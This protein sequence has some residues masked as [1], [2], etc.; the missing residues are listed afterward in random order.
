MRILTYSNPFELKRVPELWDLISSHPHYCAS[1]TLVQG[2]IKCYG[3]EAFK[4]LRPINDLLEAFY[5][6]YSANPVNDM[7]LFLTVAN[8]IRQWADGEV[9]QA[10]LFNKAEVVKAIQLLLPLE[11]DVNE[12]DREGLPEEQRRLLDLMR[13]VVDSPCYECFESCRRKTIS[14][15]RMAVEETNL[16]EINYYLGIL[17]NSENTAHELDKLY[18]ALH[19]PIKNIDEAERDT[20]RVLEYFH[21]R[22]SEDF[23][24]PIKTTAEE[25]LRL[26]KEILHEQ[27]NDY[28]DTV[29]FHGI[30]QIS[31]LMFFLFR[32]LE[33][34]GI[35]VVFLINYASNLPKI[36]QTWKEVYSWCDTRFEYSSPVDLDKGNPLGRS[37]ANVIEGKPAGDVHAN[38]IEYATMSSFATNEAGR[39]Y[40]DTIDADSGLGRLDQMATQYY[41]VQGQHCNEILRMYYPEQFREKPFLAYPIGQFIIGLYQ[42]WDFEEK[43]LRIN[44]A[45]LSECV[46][47]GVFQ[48]GDRMLE[49]IRRTR[50]LFSDV[51]SIEEYT[52]RFCGLE[53]ARNSFSSG[54]M[55]DWEILRQVSFFDLSDAD[56]RAFR[57]YLEKI[58]SLACRLFSGMSEHVDYLQHF[59]NLIEL[60]SDPKNNGGY[61]SDSERVLIEEITSRLSAPGAETVIGNTRDLQEALA[62]FLSGRM[63]AD[64]SNWI[65]RDFMQIDGAV[66]MSDKS[67][68][69][70]YHFALLSNEHM[71]KNNNHDLP[72]PLTNEM[73]GQ[74]KKYA[75]AITAVTAGHREKRH[76]L[77]YILFYGIFFSRNKNIE[78]SYIKEEDGETQSPYYLL[79]A[80]GMGKEPFDE[81]FSLGF[82]QPDSSGNLKIELDSLGDDEK[83]LFTICPFKY[84]FTKVVRTPIEYSSEY[85]IKYYLSFALAY[86]AWKRIHGKKNLASEELDRGIRE[87]KVLFPFWGESVFSDIKKQASSDLNYAL[88]NGRPFPYGYVRRKRNFL[89][90]KWVDPE[91]GKDCFVQSP[92]V[93][94]KWAEYMRSSQI[95]PSPSDLPPEGIC[96][97]CSFSEFCLRGFYD[98]HSDS[99]EG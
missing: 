94:G 55:A 96:N 44:P 5:K 3:R 13:E 47:S 49:T 92:D 39:Q 86:V 32:H 66:L 21:K 50:L 28:Y 84:L 42:M 7:Q 8:A 10:F 64:T 26:T 67:K 38:L 82:V 51:D 18:P 57:A 36:F 80:I 89:V 72:W 27:G 54:R 48:P 61:I 68:A 76:F 12:F 63:N 85:H 90:A 73:F 33:K 14:D 19:L 88:S 1:D 30:H 25:N 93:D 15:Y 23:F 22:R 60:I 58:H 29:V 40:A 53:K 46:V 95:Y 69:D 43:R 62:F 97:N 59:R 41:A 45:A 17:S 56:L 16:K 78:L 87:L 98:A 6:E 65:V 79:S 81:P 70:T 11:C 31:P 4:T 2:L 52:D 20:V 34:L 37:I 74:Y 99:G 9:R 91:T 35:Q 83:E 77:R 24:F 75:E 71:T